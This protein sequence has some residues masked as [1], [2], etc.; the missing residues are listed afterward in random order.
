MKRIMSFVAVAMVAFAPTVQAQ[1]VS[2]PAPTNGGGIFW[3]NQSLDGRRCN[4][5]YVVTGVAGN[6]ASGN[7]CDSQRPGNWLPLDD[8]NYT[9]PMFADVTP[10][11]DLFTVVG[12]IS[13]TIFGD[14]AGRDRPWGWYQ[15]ST[16]F[17]LNG[18]LPTSS[19]P[20]TATFNPI[21][22]WGL[23]ME[24]TDGT[25]A[26]ST[27][28]QFA[29][30]GYG[31]ANGNLNG[32]RLLV[33]IEDINVSPNGGSDRDYN[34]VVFALEARN[35]NLTTVPEPSTYVLMAAGLG[36]MALISRRR[37]TVTK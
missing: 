37:K 13:V 29:F 22:P 17:G 34:D 11:Q 36:A 3:D 2:T 35:G 33:G 32:R 20:V 1:F 8:P 25:T 10:G 4:I 19:T 14:I 12:P 23:W 27:G 24:L 26:Y 6:G 15:G 5:G 9:N 21:A 31:N 7:G 18:L 16:Y 28:N 30:F